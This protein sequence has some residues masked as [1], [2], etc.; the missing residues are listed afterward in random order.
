MG[1]GIYKE[2]VSFWVSCN[3]V[4]VKVRQQVVKF[5]SEGVCIY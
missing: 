2:L 5:W 3:V 4:R 1:D